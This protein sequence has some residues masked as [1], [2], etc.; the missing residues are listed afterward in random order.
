MHIKAH[1]GTAFFAYMQIFT[2]K[3]AIF[4]QN[5]RIPKKSTIF[6][7]ASKNVPL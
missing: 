6:A 7:A 3:N 2:Q 4:P 5:L 1:K